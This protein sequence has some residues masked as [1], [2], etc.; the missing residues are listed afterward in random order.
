MAV[1]LNGV[2]N[3]TH[4]FLP[5]LRAT[6]PDCQHRLDPVVRAVRTPNSPA[7]TASKH[8]VLG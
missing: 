7:Y 3:V 8:G 6:G 2:F 1:N 5:A 4:A